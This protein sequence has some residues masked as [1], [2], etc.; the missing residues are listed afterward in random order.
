MYMKQKVVISGSGDLQEHVA[1]WKNHFEDLGYDVI[2]VP[3]PRTNAQEH[4]QQLE[5]LYVD[6]YNAIDACDVFFC[7]N[8]DKNGTAGYIGANGTAELIYAVTSKL[9]NHVDLKIFVLKQPS[10]E[11]SAYHEINSFMKLGWVELYASDL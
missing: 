3:K 10:K 6:F 1:Q 4:S 2:A 5:S 7:I 8:E 11:V 9:R